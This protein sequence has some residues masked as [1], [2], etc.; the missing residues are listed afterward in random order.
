MNKL[1]LFIL[2]CIPFFVIALIWLYYPVWIFYKYP[3]GD[4]IDGKGFVDELGPFGDVYGALNTLF[5]G[6]AFAGLII[7]IR[8]Q[9]KELSDTRAELKE[10]SEQFKKQTE[11]LAKQVFE[12][13]FF[14]L[15]KLYTES[16]D[17]LS[18]RESL[19]SEKVERMEEVGV[20][21]RQ[22]LSIL[23]GRMEVWCHIERHD[24][25]RKRINKYMDV[26]LSK[27]GRV[28]ERAIKTLNRLLT[29]V[30]RSDLSRKD[31]FFYMG[32]LTAQMSKD[33]MTLLFYY[34]MYRK[35]GLEDLYVRSGILGSFELSRDITLE[36]FMMYGLYA[37]GDFSSDFWDGAITKL[38]LSDKKDEMVIS[39]MD[40]KKIKL[41]NEVYKFKKLV[42]RNDGVL[43]IDR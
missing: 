29:F 19:S 18:F 2:Y 32:L 5:S 30:D 34:G 12:V 43:L 33:E 21:G 17:N 8:L 6:L 25:Y 3:F 10:Q 24:Y 26:F 15:L 4:L 27:Y 9:S 35:S 31:K 20:V 37:Y 41:P 40:G 11:G 7:S 14:Q 39:C 1:K 36:E 42:R 23:S 13:T 28:V 22:V 38:L 16:V